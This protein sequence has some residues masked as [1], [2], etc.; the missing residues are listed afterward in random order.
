MRT[1]TILTT[2]LK[3]ADR[4][5]LLRKEEADESPRATLFEIALNADLLEERFLQAAPRIRRLFYACIP[6]V[7]A[8]VIEAYCIRH[9]Y[10]AVISWS[11]PHALL[12][13]SL[14][15]LT[16]SRTPHIALMFWIS[17]PRKAAILKRVYSH[18][19]RI[20]LW[21]ST[22]RD[23]AVNTLRIPPSKIKFIRYY[24]DQQ[25]WRPMLTETDMICSVGVE[26]RDY[27]TLIE[28]MRGLDIRC[29]IA[30]G[31]ARGKVFSTVK[32]IYENGT[33]PPNISVGLLSALELRRLY[34]R[35]R[36]VVVPLLPSDSD[37]GLT[38]IL[39]AMAM[40]KAVICSRTRGQVDVIQDG[41][42]GIF[43]PQGDPE[44]L[45]KAIEYLWKHPD[46]AEKMGGEAREYI[47]ENNTWDHFVHTV[48]SIVEEVIREKSSNSDSRR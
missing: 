41:R 23:F 28:A 21:T 19:D 16:R 14:L 22:H 35:S 36:F 3:K 8:Q 30:A 44:V 13:A 47:E 38:T 7:I 45:Q 1:L 40:G 26:M 42:T 27:P 15:K 20:V 43:V 34:A 2:G 33:L 31:P 6:K 37:N 10:D 5:E 29:H 24:V 9:N 18:I 11:D 48:K 12:F 32:A 25:F 4:R 39:E 17:K 46:E